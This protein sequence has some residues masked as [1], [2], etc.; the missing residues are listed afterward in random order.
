MT[1]CAVRCKKL[2]VA[3]EHPGPYKFAI[4]RFII[5]FKVYVGRR[6][7]K[8]W[9]VGTR[10]QRWKSVFYSRTLVSS[11]T[12][13]SGVKGTCYSL[14]TIPFTGF[15]VSDSMCEE[16]EVARMTENYKKEGLMDLVEIG[17]RS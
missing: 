15:R 14:R 5:V 2:L 16:E 6:G 8:D 11:Q 9:C 1:K 4:V 3:Y 12:K 10:L 13:R 17:V 7:R